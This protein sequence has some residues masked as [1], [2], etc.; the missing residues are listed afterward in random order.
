MGSA[1]L[2]LR[3]CQQLAAAVS[4]QTASP[5]ANPRAPK[6]STS[7]GRQPLS[8]PP[9]I[10]FPTRRIGPGR[11]DRISGGLWNRV[12]FG[13][14]LT[15]PM[16]VRQKTLAHRTMTFPEPLL[17]FRFGEQP[18]WLAKSLHSGSAALSGRPGSR[19]PGSLL[20]PHQ[21]RGYQGSAEHG[22]HEPDVP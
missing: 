20:Q 13:R 4:E 12:I 3:S 19:E 10:E 2:R 15:A 14:F 8:P 5:S 17:G 18:R 21:R 22:S 7:S 11:A 16:F 9:A 1:Y 6:P